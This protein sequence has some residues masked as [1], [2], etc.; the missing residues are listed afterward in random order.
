MSELLLALAS[1]RPRQNV[2]SR[3][4]DLSDHISQMFVDI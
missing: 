1:H 2:L 4:A 3:K